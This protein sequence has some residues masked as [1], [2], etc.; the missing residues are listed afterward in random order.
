MVG[1]SVDAPDA[2]KKF[3]EKFGFPFDLLSDQSRD[4]SIAY[5]AADAKDAPRAKRISYLIGP[6][7]RISKAY[8]EV[9]PAE[10]IAQVLA[11]LK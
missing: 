8:A 3:K 5:G 10:H 4:V 9:K 1:V 11:D 2:N 7:G 6:D